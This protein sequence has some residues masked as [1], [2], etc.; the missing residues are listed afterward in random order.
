MSNVKEVMVRQCPVAVLVLCAVTDPAYQSYGQRYSVCLFLLIGT[1]FYPPVC[2]TVQAKMRCRPRKLFICV[3]PAA[4]QFG[5]LCGG[6]PLQ[7]V[8]HAKCYAG[9]VCSSCRISHWPFNSDFAVSI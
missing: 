5:P 7:F 9:H 1:S 3:L 6:L 2:F 8:D 4:I